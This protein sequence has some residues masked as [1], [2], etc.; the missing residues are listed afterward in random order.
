MCKT[1]DINTLNCGKKKKN[2]TDRKEVLQVQLR[3]WVSSY[4]TILKCRHVTKW[5]P[6]SSRS[7]AHWSH[8]DHPSIHGLPAIVHANPRKDYEESLKQESLQSLCDS[9][10]RSKLG[11]ECNSMSEKQLASYQQ[12][13]WPHNLYGDL[14]GRVANI[15]H[16]HLGC[17]NSQSVQE[18]KKVMLFNSLQNELWL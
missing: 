15:L 18:I 16:M 11:T 5:N 17:K 9:G 3:L 2:S 10:E 12:D 7:V 13:P 8:H 6:Y 14:V 1:K 4:Q